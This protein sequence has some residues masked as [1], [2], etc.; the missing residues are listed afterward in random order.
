MPSRS[1][2][3]KGR[4]PDPAV[5]ERETRVME[6][7]IAGAT[8]DQI[9]QAVGYTDPSTAREAYLRAMR[10]TLQPLADELREQQHARYERLIRSHWARAIGAGGT[11]PS[12][13]A[14]DVVLRA[15]K[16]LAELHGLNAPVKV[17]QEVTVHDGSDI[18]RR[19]QELAELLAKNDPQEAP[20]T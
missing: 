16:G 5:I 13:K 4:A 1:A 18:D 2:Q 17:Q 3:R 9:A 7:R 19:V 20:A 6:L 14:V 15:M 8:F 12:P 10:R 11:D